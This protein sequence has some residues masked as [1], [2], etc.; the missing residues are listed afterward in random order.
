MHDRYSADFWETLV[1]SQHSCCKKA[2]T[3]GSAD[4][5]KRWLL[6]ALTFESADDLKRS[7]V[8][9]VATRKRWVIFL[10]ANNVLTFRAAFWRWL[11]VL[12][13]GAD[14]K[15]WHFERFLM[16]PAAQIDALWR[17]CAEAFR[18]DRCVLSCALPCVAVRCSVCC[19]D[20][21]IEKALR[22]DECV[23]QC[24]SVCCSAWDL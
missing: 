5:W 17:P 19:S 24:V 23:L 6:E 18:C 12:T 22:Y 21:V 4:F 1:A 11:L 2:L 8:F 14:L 10:V 15:R 20:D 13:F 3:F 9:R 16:Q 7:F